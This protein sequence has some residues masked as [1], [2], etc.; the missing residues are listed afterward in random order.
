M[1]G[2]AAVVGASVEIDTEACGDWPDGPGVTDARGFVHVISELVSAYRQ[3][4]ILPEP[5]PDT[6]SATAIAERAAS[7]TLLSLVKGMGNLDWPQVL[8]QQTASRKWTLFETG[9]EGPENAWSS[10]LR[11]FQPV[12]WSPSANEYLVG[13]SVSSGG[14]EQCFNVKELPSLLELTIVAWEPGEITISDPLPGG[15]LV[16]FAPWRLAADADPKES[17]DCKVFVEVFFIRKADGARLTLLTQ[18]ELYVDRYGDDSDDEAA[19]HAAAS[20]SSYQYRDTSDTEKLW[21]PNVLRSAELEVYLSSEL[22][23]AKG[24]STVVSLEVHVSMVDAYSWDHA[25]EY[26][27]DWLESASGLL[28]LLE[29]SSYA[30]RWV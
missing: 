27:K 17:E 10:R 1:P 28:G 11:T 16:P 20:K 7:D 14:V 8:Q 29:T 24:E 21:S 6:I 18:C 13:V 30:C 5:S 3:H 19:E 12:I 25:R 2:C 4:W 23:D 22:V 9:F 15:K 26:P